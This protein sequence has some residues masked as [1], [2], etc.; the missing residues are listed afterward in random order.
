[1]DHFELVGPG[2][3]QNGA[4]VERAR[5]DDPAVAHLD[6]SRVLAVEAGRHD[7]DRGHLGV[8]VAEPPRAVGLDEAAARGGGA[9]QEVLA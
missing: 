6:L 2:V 9:D 3:E 7:H 4:A 8:E 5:D 1:M